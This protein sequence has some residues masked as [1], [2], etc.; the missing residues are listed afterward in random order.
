MKK[1]TQLK[2][3]LQ[4]DRTEFLMEAHNGL[5]ARIVEEAGFTG[6]WGSGL[7]ISAALGVRDN[8]EASWTQVL[9]VVEFMS[10]A[11]EI[12]ILLDGDTG[13]GDFNTLR[14]VVR[15]LEQRQVAGICIEDKLFPKT[16]SF[17]GGELQELADPQEFAGKIRAAKDTQQD[18]DFCVVARTEAF[19]TGW[20]LEEALRRAHVYR[21]AGVDALLIHSKITRADEI[22][23][24]MK[25]WDHDTPI[26]IVPTKYYSTPTEVFEDLGVSL[27]IWANH[28]VRSSI[29]AM[30]RTARSIQTERNLFTVEDGVAP[31]QEIFRLQGAEELK[32]AERRYRPLQ[33]AATAIILAASRGEELKALTAE[34]PKAMLTLGNEPILQKLFDAFRSI[35]VRDVHAVVGYRA[36]AVDVPSVK[37]VLNEQYAST[38]EVFSLACAAEH[39]RG[40][41]Y[42]SFGDIIF[43]RYVLQAL[44][45]GPGDIVIVV[46]SN[47][48][49]E[50]PARYTEL[51]KASRPYTPAYTEE[52]ALMETMDPELHPDEADGEWIGLMKLTAA[53][54]DAMRDALEL[55]GSQDGFETMRMSRLLNHLVSAGVE[56]HV[57]YIAGNWLDID[58]IEKYSEALE[59]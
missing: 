52:P 36:D 20:G 7:A 43:K 48:G 24:F 31:V 58:D 38:K 30:Q 45:G 16:N 12:P 56:V 42:I 32:E 15:K 41:A 59:F 27:V 51:I 19:I 25:E 26:V 37:K 50:P 1:T 35:G 53:G 34:R 6:I 49:A 44:Q 39:I 40:D 54:S 14:R 29:E 23:S 9:D 33:P 10:D 4:S 22:V 11:V 46:D 2:N 55:L 21:E 3:L 13:Y 8:N 18:A 28:L 57:S 17:I 5:S 47:T